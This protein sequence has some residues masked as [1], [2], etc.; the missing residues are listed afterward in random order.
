VTE[1]SGGGE[2]EQGTTQLSPIHVHVRH[3]FLSTAGMSVIATR[4]YWYESFPGHVE[5]ID[6]L[7]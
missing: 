7:K 2:T 4:D 6:K 5:S 1:A 3:L